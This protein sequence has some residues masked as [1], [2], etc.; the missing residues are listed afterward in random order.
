M[1]SSFLV[2]GKNDGNEGKYFVKKIFVIKIPGFDYVH[3]YN[4]YEL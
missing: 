1:S 4:S 3:G 2:F